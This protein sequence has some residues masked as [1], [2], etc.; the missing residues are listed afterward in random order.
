MHAMKAQLS[1]DKKTSVLRGDLA[2]VAA[3]LALGL[4]G[5]KTWISPNQLRFETSRSNIDLAMSLLPTG[6]V[7][8]R[9]SHPDEAKLFDET[10]TPALDDPAPNFRMEPFDFQRENFERFKD[11]PTWA[12]FSVQGCVDRDTEYLS[13]S[14]W[15]KISEY[16]WGQVAQYNLD[17]TANFVQP[18]EY[19]VKPCKEMVHFKTKYGCDQM[20]SKDHRILLQSRVD[21]IR[22]KLPHQYWRDDVKRDENWQLFETTP[23]RLMQRFEKRFSKGGRVPGFIPTHFMMEGDGIDIGEFDL[24][25]QVAF[26]ADGSF[27][28]KAMV[29]SPSGNRKGSIRIKKQRKKERLEWLLDRSSVEWSKKDV[30]G[31]FSIYTF[32]PPI[33]EK[34]FVSDFWWK[35]SVEQKRMISEE[36]LHWDGSR[37]AFCSHDERDA[38]F[39]HFCFSST[40]RRSRLSKSG[41]TMYVGTSNEPIALGV[42]NVV[43]SPDGKMYCFTVPSSYLVF[44]RNGCVFVSGNSGKTKVAFDITSHRFLKGAVTGVIVLSNPKGV[45]AQWI[46]E[47]LPKHIW[48]G[49]EVQ[50][51]VWEGKK[52]PH[53]FGNPSDKL[54]IVSGNIDMLKGKGYSLLEQFARQHRE[55]LLVLVDESDSI[56]N[57]NSARSKK[58]RKLAEVTRQRAIMTGTPIAKDLTDEF[59]QFYFLDPNILGHKY[60]T[61]FRAQYCIMGGFENRT[62]VGH[63]NLEQFKKLTAPYIF[64]ATKEDLNLPP[65]VYDELAFDLTAEQ[66]R[67]IKEIRE[68]F[69]ASLESGEISSVSSGAVALL[70]IQQISNGF[71]AVDDGQISFIDNPRLEALRALRKDI[72]GPVVIWCRF[73]ADV[74]LLKRELGDSAATYYGE[75]SPAERAAAKEAFIRG[76]VRELIATPGAAGKGVDGLQLVC[77]D[78]IYYSN[79]FNAIDRWQS[80]DRTDRIGGQGTAS[81]FDLIGRGSADRGILRNLKHKKSI[82]ELALSDLK[83]MM[84]EM[85]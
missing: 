82:S 20:L 69:Y 18:D 4:E 79:S 44:R 29:S 71:V 78:A 81:Y 17:G 73:K 8:D 59:S 37:G 85:A 21:G 3:R 5:R 48:N 36:C 39:I 28:S 80:E 51:L 30:A 65:K 67:L 7:E 64:R 41:K 25:L 53:W 40:G 68:T 13:P 52:P 35:A 27:G 6:M 2:P 15:K 43:P 57:M 61:S 33:N 50:S 32:I 14:G 63:K 19:H 55:K 46:N 62:V 72:S 26:I 56:K 10:Q 77:S 54:Q 70:R 47:Q 9:R 42:P 24:R 66:R 60:L 76:D 11:L 74:E 49:I 75:T 83:Q 58:L 23:E 16:E 45:H 12:I 38:D 34:H 22:R 1:I 31:G 84:D